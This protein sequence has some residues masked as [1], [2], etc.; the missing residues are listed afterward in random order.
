MTFLFKQPEFLQQAEQYLVSPLI[1]PTGDSREVQAFSGLRFSQWLSSQLEKEF[2]LNK[3]WMEC[4]PILLGSWARQELC[5]KSDL[6]V[7]FC[8][9]SQKVLQLVNELNLAGVKLRY[10]V[11]SNESDWTEGVELFDVLA[12]LNA[13]PLTP[14]S[15]KKLFD[16][17]RLIWRKLPQISK[18]LLKTLQIERKKRTELFDSLTNYLEPHLKSGPGGLR[19]LEQGLQVYSLFGSRIENSDYAIRILNYYKNYWLTIRHKLHLSG[20]NDQYQAALQHEIYKWLGFSSQIESMRSF[21]RGLSRVHFYSDWLLEAAITAEKTPKNKKTNLVVGR[22]SQLSA[23]LELIA[24]LLVEPNLSTQKKV[25]ER[26]DSVVGSLTPLQLKKFRQKGLAVLSDITLTDQQIVAFFRSRLIDKILPEFARLV[27]HVQ[28]DHYH[29]F[30]VDAHILQARREVRRAFENPKH[31][32]HLDFVTR[33]FKRSDWQILALVSLYH[34]IGKGLDK[35]HSLAGVEILKRDEAIIAN[36][37]TIQ[38]VQHL[39]LNHLELSKAAF[40]LNPNAL[41]TWSY[42]NKKEVSGEQLLRLAVFTA[43]DIRA[44]NPE[45]WNE[46]KSSLL[47]TLVKKMVE[48]E[49]NRALSFQSYLDK[50]KIQIHAQDLDTFLIENISP[51]HLIKDLK[52]CRG[53][54]QESLQVY[55][56]KNKLW[57]RFYAPEDRKG[58]LR[59]L[60]IKVSGSGLS[61]SHAAVNTL[62]DFGVY[63]WLQ[64]SGVGIDPKKIETKL[65]NSS[66][67]GNIQMPTVSFQKIEWIDF[68]EG[69]GNILFK[70]LDQ[71]FILMTAIQS[72]TEMGADIRMARVH[73]WGRQVEDIF[74]IVIEGEPQV[75]LEALKNRLLSKK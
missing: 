74:E 42:L 14:T 40:K 13:R 29:R 3:L 34:D 27:G 53:E 4:D 60:M 23:A 54:K 59:E 16:Q 12:L 62:K 66:S 15:A 72:L 46:W 35:D 47:A 19:D 61:V 67:R 1:T 25:R 24:S 63:N 58:L 48:P 37:K 10:R 26:M 52:K 21:Q 70:A 75:F 17:Q 49:T 11:P 69:R 39:V 9:D 38:A 7:I 32:G 65:K 64:I 6:D 8:G 51:E 18:E 45:A 22:K 44:T 56:I 68:N 71:S 55:K 28:H 50:A 43:L 41:S 36:K 73:T 30:T 57:L 33:K 2:A 5:L 31:L 20:G